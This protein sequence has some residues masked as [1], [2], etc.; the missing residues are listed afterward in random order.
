VTAEQLTRLFFRLLKTV[1][2]V[3]LAN[4]LPYAVKGPHPMTREPHDPAAEVCRSAAALLLEEVVR[5]GTPSGP[6][7]FP[8]RGR[9]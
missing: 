1:P 6:P 2:L 7:S 8:P 3:E 9:P 4:A 5:L